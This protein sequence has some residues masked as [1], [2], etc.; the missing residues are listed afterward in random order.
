MV[1]K[2]LLR[3]GCFYHYELPSTVT[4]SVLYKVLYLVISMTFSKFALFG[5]LARLMLVYCVCVISC[6]V[7]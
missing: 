1:S 3:L 5:A 2:E 7:L 4:R 6:V